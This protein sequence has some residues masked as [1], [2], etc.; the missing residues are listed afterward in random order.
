MARK[1]Y[2]MNLP[3][4]VTGT[5]DHSDLTLY[6]YIIDQLKI[7]MMQYNIHEIATPLLESAALFSRALGT[8]TDVVSKEMFY[9]RSHEN[10]VDDEQ[11]CLRPEATAST[12]RMFLE[13]Q[14]A[15][16]VPWRVFSYGPMFRYERP[17]KGRFRQ[18]NQ[19]NIEMIGAPSIAY[20][21]DLICLLDRF[22]QERLSL[23]SYALH[24]NFLGCSDDRV[25][26]RTILRDFMHSAAIASQVCTT[27]TVRV[28]KNIMRI[29]DCK[30]AT[31]QKLYQ[32]APRITD[33]LC[34]ICAS[35]WCTV[36]ETL[37]VLSVSYGV[38][39][40][41]VRGLD[42]Y[43]KTVFEFSSSD[44]GAQNAFCGGG[45]YELATLFGASTS[46]PSVGAAI[47]ME[48]LVLLLT[49][50]RDTL[51][52]NVSPMLHVV[53]P[54][55]NAQVALAL[56]VADQLRAHDICTM[57]IF[58]DVGIK[59]QLRK[60]SNAGA[61]YVLL[62]GS[63]EQESGHIMVRDMLKG[64]QELVAQTDLILYLHNRT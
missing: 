22:F 48:R 45:R 29:F 20:D 24:I 6:N 30:Q 3:K 17:Q 26:Y 27:C 8:H 47:G 11:I 4:K 59:Q 60:A 21:V 28:E 5:Q 51:L 23:H 37:G 33:H 2:S 61:R 35:E 40:Q 13:N 7:H 55:D 1:K 9:I 15:F 41:L 36:Q 38:N 50:L 12:M 46:V 31:C 32:Q 44:L 42:Y 25:A 56:L 14:H 43:N 54:M 19:F 10:S 58:P 49:P 62:I 34:T 18:F 53:I 16:M 57:L 39:H 64:T 63:Q 52:Q